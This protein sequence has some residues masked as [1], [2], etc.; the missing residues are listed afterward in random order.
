MAE[1]NAAFES[2]NST[3]K[4][5]LSKHN[6]KPALAIDIIPYPLGW[7][8]SDEQFVYMGG[9]FLGIA[10]ILKKTNFIHHN[11]RWGGDWNRN[12]D[13]TDQKL[14]DRAHFEIVT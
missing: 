5:P 14:I 12:N 1:Q 9:L 4:Y 11:I 6:K 3:L 2:G 13:L 7:K 10:A 8:A